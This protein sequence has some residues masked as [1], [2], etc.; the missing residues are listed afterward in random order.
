[1]RSTPNLRE[2]FELAQVALKLR[3]FYQKP[4]HAK[5]VFYVSW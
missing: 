3:V 2:E 5:Q 4:G 1:M